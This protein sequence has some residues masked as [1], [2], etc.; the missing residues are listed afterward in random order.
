MVKKAL[1][2]GAVKYTRSFEIHLEYRSQIGE[3]RKRFAV[4]HSVQD[5]P[6]DKMLRA[7]C[8]A[9]AMVPWVAV[10]CEL[11]V[12]LIRELYRGVR[13]TVLDR[14]AQAIKRAATY[15]MFF[16]CRCPSGSQHISMLVL[17]CLLT[18]RELF[19]AMTAAF[20]TACPASGMTGSSE[21]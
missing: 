20:R 1:T 11:P 21:S 3:E 9:N 12:S 8:K 16:L 14:K 5:Y 17:A 2:G 19:Q 6:E 18:V 10:A 7:W 15:L 4:H 13:L